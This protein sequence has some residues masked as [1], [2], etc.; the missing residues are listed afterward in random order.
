[1][2]TSMRHAIAAATAVAVASAGSLAMTGPVSASPAAS[3]VAAKDGIKV[4]AKK[5]KKK[6]K[7][8]RYTMGGDAYGTEIVAGLLGLRSDRTA[9]SWVGCTQQNRQMST[10][11]VGG[12]VLPGN[13]FLDLGVVRSSTKTRKGSAAKALGFPSNTAA[14]SISSAKV[15]DV[16][17][18]PADGPH[19]V[20]TGLESEARAWV[21]KKGKF[22]TTQKYKTLNIDAKT[23][24]A[25]L[26]QLL[27]QQGLGGLLDL[28]LGNIVEPLID[29]VGGVLKVA[30]LGEISMGKGVSK[31]RKNHAISYSTALEVRLYGT[32]MKRSADDIVVE[33][34]RSRARIN[35]TNEPGRFGGYA[36]ALDATLLDGVLKTSKLAHQPVPCMGTGG[37]WKKSGVADVNLLGLGLVEVGAVTSAVQTK[38]T[39]RTT[40]TTKSKAQTARIAIGG[41]N[42]LVIEAITSEATAQRNRLGKLSTKS[43]VDVGSISVAGT[44]YSLGQLLNPVL[45][46][47]DGVLSGLGIASIKTHVKRKVKNGI[48]VIALQIKLLNGK[49]ADVKIG[50]VEAKVS[51]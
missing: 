36:S 38:G 23:G 7:T 33:L 8:T 17:L 15:A 12:S 3:S 9:F 11:L 16:R 26:D 47:L 51:K 39:R 6:K 14:A 28:L 30:G 42:G 40:R 41:N 32:D 37:A 10:A 34:G 27:G 13:A 24:I 44:K 45:S 25:P 43:F 31:E 2:K 46:G 5:K 4:Q 49:G 21:S 29:V 18:G 48:G 20:I 1:M 35:R 22:N 19:L 50:D